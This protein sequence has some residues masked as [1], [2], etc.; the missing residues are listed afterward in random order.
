MECYILSSLLPSP[1][2]KERPKL[3]WRFVQ[4][5]CSIQRVRFPSWSSQNV[6]MLGTAW[7]LQCAILE[8][9]QW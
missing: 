6:L 4:R 2:S 1:S 5:F 7:C 9:Q 8:L 3:D